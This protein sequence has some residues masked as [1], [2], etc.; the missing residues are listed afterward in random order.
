MHAGYARGCVGEWARGP[1]PFSAQM[2]GDGMHVLL[3]QVAKEVDQARKSA[4]SD[5]SNYLQL[6]PDGTYLQFRHGSY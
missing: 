2:N 1:V 6:K 3:C 5:V 4:W